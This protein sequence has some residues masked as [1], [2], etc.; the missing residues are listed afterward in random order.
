[1]Y[2][3]FLFFFFFFC[4]YFPCLL[5]RGLNTLGR[6]YAIPIKG[7]IFCD[8][9]FALYSTPSPFRKKVSNLLGKQSA[10]MGT[11]GFT[12][13]VVPFQKVTKNNFDR[14]VSPERLSISLK[15]QVHQSNAY[16]EMFLFCF[17]LFFWFVCFFCSGES[18]KP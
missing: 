17:V 6:I 18:L 16:V 4:I 3:F 12:N 13:R 10:P 7:D 8:F 15:C 1:M 14:V 5:L 9:L 11:N 2:F